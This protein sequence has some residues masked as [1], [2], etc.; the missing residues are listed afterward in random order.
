MAFNELSERKKHVKCIAKI[1]I[2]ACSGSQWR[3]LRRF[4]L[5]RKRQR[6]SIH[7]NNYS[8]KPHHYYTGKN[9]V[10]VNY[11]NYSFFTI[12]CYTAAAVATVVQLSSS[13]YGS[14]YTCFLYTNLNHTTNNNSNDVIRALIMIMYRGRKKTSKGVRLQYT[15][16][17]FFRI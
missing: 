14:T 8:T 16:N 7:V 15:Y 4:P 9:M 6:R 11:N 3:I 17:F 1:T 10:I 13:P 2:I 5:Y 12:D